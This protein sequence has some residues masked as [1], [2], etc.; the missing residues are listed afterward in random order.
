MTPRTPSR[1]WRAWL[2]PVLAASIGPVFAQ[3]A[4]QHLNELPPS[5]PPV[6]TPNAGS[7][8]LPPLAPPPPAATPPT[9]S[10]ALS[11]RVERIV[12]T[13]NTVVSTR[14]L[15][16]L[17]APYVN[18]PLSGGDIEALRRRVTQYYVDAGYINSGAILSDNAYS[19]GVLT[20]TI[21]EGRLSDI[22]ISGLGYL[23]PRYITSRLS[24]GDGVLNIDAL[25]EKFQML[26]GDPLIA[27]MNARVVPGAAAGEADLDLDVVRAAAFQL[28]GYFNNYRPPSIGAEALGVRASA[29]DLTGQGDE[30]DVILETP[31]EGGGTVNSSV[32]W[33]MPIFQ[34]DT[35]LL[36]QYDHGL[37]AVTEEPVDVLDV[38]SVLVSRGLGIE[39]TLYDSLQQHLSVSLVRAGRENRTTLLGTP[40]SFIQG[41]PN[42]DTVA[43]VWRFA[44]DYSWRTTTDVLALRSTFS[45]VTDNEAVP[46]GLPST[47]EPAS[48]YSI[49]LGQLQYTRQVMDN[50]AEIVARGTVQAT[51]SHLLPLDAMTIGGDSSVRGYRENQL[52]ADTGEVLNLEFHY[53][54]PHI[55]PAG[56]EMSV[57]PFTDVGHGKVIGQGSATLSSLGLGTQLRWRGLQFDVSKAYR[58]SYP[59]ALVTGH[60][61]L[62]DRGI[63]FQLQY[64]VF[65]N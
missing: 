24:P 16:G 37:S 30:L 34:P 27:Q 18:R 8:E 14:V 6:L 23:T 42:G 29:R 65:A 58:L 1:A 13:G 62:Q 12:F 55:L 35:F 50:G 22:R 31:I 4:S 40:F 2:L 32:H 44:Q 17:A 7:F 9:R 59:D 26:L 48:A 54:L 60:G 61:N 20:Y 43:P 3:D 21:I 10:G 57:I 63:Y 64:T 5:S 47:A 52:L 11:L 45:Y 56:V 38:R 51:R 19:G 39:E 28:T 41:E 25:R 53:P 46:L 49:W 15:D 36:V 33:R